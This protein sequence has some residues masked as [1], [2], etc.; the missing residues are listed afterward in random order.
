MIT[1]KTNKTAN[2]DSISQNLIQEVKFL[3]NLL[4]KRTQNIL[5][6]RFGLFN[7]KKETLESIGTFYKVTRER[8]RQIQDHGISVLKTKILP[9]NQIKFKKRFEAINQK[10]EELG[11]V[12]AEE[13]LLNHLKKKNE[14][15][16]YLKFLLVLNPNIV[17][18]KEN[19]DFRARWALVN[20]K[21]DA[22]IIEGALKSLFSSINN[23]EVL[24]F[25]DVLKRFQAKIKNN[26]NT[27]FAAN[28]N[29][30]VANQ[31]FTS[32]LG[33]TKT[34]GQN[35]FGEW[36]LS[37]S[38]HVYPKGV[39]DYAYLTM[40][41]H[42]SPMHFREVSRAI[43]DNFKKPAHTQTIH[44][45]LIKDDR[46]VLVGRGLYAL[47]EWGYVPGSVRD[48][49]S[50]ILKAHGRILKDDLMKKLLKERHVKETTVAINL[51][52]K[53]LFRKFPDGTYGLA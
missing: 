43:Q 37:D 8:V 49:I 14:D 42:G 30:E 6:R 27:D 41:R 26:L 29:T 20:K 13:H 53:N 36:G 25:D 45:E 39:K 3:I 34:I 12:A 38:C 44:N 2:E 32:W 10:I 48:V 31:V 17:C 5:S 18:F 35:I 11:N 51:Q 46:F 1:N 33:L 47:K 24:S 15:V 7:K 21:S 28:P 52:N 50:H 19:D 23:E 22:L 4:P 16:N 9:A 40:R